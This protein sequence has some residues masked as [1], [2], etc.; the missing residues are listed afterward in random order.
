MTSTFD[1]E[2]YFRVFFIRQLFVTWKLL[3]RLWCNFTCVLLG[4]M[5]RSEGESIFLR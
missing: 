2:S 5:V 4:S 1:L 3:V